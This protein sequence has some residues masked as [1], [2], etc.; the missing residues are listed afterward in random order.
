[1][2]H[3]DEYLWNE[4]AVCLLSLCRLDLEEDEVSSSLLDRAI[5]MLNKAFCLGNQHAL[6][7]LCCAYALAKDTDRAL[8]YL[9][10]AFDVGI[11][12]PAE[13]MAEDDWLDEIR[14]LAR[15][16]E[17][18]EENRKEQEDLAD[19]EDSEDPEGPEEPE[20][21]PDRGNLTAS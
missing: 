17:M 4:W 12:P 21:G 11:H 7:N 20:R 9:E 2:D 13:D 10:K 8:D 19:P 18:L 3:E 5:V 1:M 16:Q 6:Y 14:P 15:F